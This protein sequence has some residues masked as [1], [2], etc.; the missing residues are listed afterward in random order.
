MDLQKQNFNLSKKCEDLENQ[1]HEQQAFM[2]KEK[3]V[4]ELQTCF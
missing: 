3:G 1:V 4:K 2:D